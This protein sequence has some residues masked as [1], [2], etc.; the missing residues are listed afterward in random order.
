MKNHK[1][2]RILFL[3]IKPIAL[4][5]IL[6]LFTTCLSNTKTTDSR[7]VSIAANAKI[8]L[9]KKLD[10]KQKGAHVF[11]RL[12]SI[13][14]QP[15]IQNNIKWITLVSYSDQKDFDSPTVRHHRGDRKRQMRRDS[16]WQ[17]QINLAH[18]AG[19]KVFLKPHIWLHAPT[20]GKWRSDIFPTNEGNWKLWKKNY[21]EFILRYAKIAQKNNVELFCVG[22]E[23]TRLAIEK[24]EYWK[25]LIKEVRSVYS[26]ELTYA[27]NWYNAFQVITF[28]DDLDYIGIQAY[29][30]LTENENP[31]VEQISKGWDKH[32][33]AMETIN[34]KYDRKILFTELGYK[35]TSDSAITP[36]EWV[37]DPSIREQKSFSTITQANC[38]EAFFNTIWQKEWFVGVHIWQLRSD[39]TG[40]DGRNHLDFTPQGKLA[41]KIIAKGFE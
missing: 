40:S 18:S 34:K 28:W 30:P 24:P 1:I 26:G 41:E 27:A 23:L 25:N 12:D 7:E 17:S 19:F 31:S 33:P 3:I 6:L 37:D 35:S 39:F 10:D 8:S 22:T 16:M 14:L 20:E 11:G 36:W 13:R 9:A 32:I 15:F 2:N 4:L 29:F 5:C 38:Y 21:R